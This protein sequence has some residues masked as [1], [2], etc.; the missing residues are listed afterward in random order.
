MLKTNMA[1]L[2]KLNNCQL[3][4][5]QDQKKIIFLDFDGV[6]NTMYYQDKSGKRI[7]IQFSLPFNPFHLAN[8]YAIGLLNDLAVTS[9]AVL[10]ITSSWR[11]DPDCNNYLH[12]SGLD[13]AIIIEG[14]TEQADT[15]DGAIFNYLR[16]HPNFFSFVILDDMPTMHQLNPWFVR[17]NSIVGLTDH[18][19]KRALDILKTPFSFDQIPHHS[20]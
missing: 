1:N 8:H 10:V 3:L 9:K 16:N 19:C 14:K 7:P 15:R 17:T 6:I 12:E 18:D 13:P 2:T 4:A 20:Y 5:D 11:F